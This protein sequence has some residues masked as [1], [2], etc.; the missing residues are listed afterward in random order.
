M[1]EIRGHRR[2]CGSDCCTHPPLPSVR[3]GEGEEVKRV[4]EEGVRS[5]GREKKIM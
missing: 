1:R 4:R 3:V 5:E 2:S